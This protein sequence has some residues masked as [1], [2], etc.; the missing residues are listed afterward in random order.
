M[1]L[2]VE[3]SARPDSHSYYQKEQPRCNTLW[4]RQGRLQ[5]HVLS[6]RLVCTDRPGQ[7]N[8]DTRG[9]LIIDMA[10]C[11]GIRWRT[12]CTIPTRS[13]VRA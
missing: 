3:K 4:G 11:A 2:F 6:A 10:D 1:R 8:L 5:E 12:P 13:W 7:V 9:L